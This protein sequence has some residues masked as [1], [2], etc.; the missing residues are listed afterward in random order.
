MS[1]EAIIEKALSMD[2]VLFLKDGGLSYRAPAGSGVPQALREEIVANKT[3]IVDYLRYLEI[4]AG[5]TPKLPPILRREAGREA[6][7]SYGQQQLMLVDR[8]GGGSRQFNIQGVFRADGALDIGALQAAIRRIVERH[9]VLRTHLIERDGDFV[10]VVADACEVPF[11]VVDISGQPAGER[12]RRLAELIRTDAEA[13]FDLERGPMLRMQVVRLSGR[14]HAILLCMHHVASDGWSLGVFVKELKR[15]Y[16]QALTGEIAAAPALT[17]QYADYA[18][19]QR[20]LLEGPFR[21]EAV[22]FWKDYLEGIPDCHVLPLDHARPAEPDVAAIRIDRRLDRAQ[23]ARLKSVCSARGATLFMLLQTAFSLLLHRF[24][25]A[26]DIVVGTPMSGRIDAALEPLVGLFINT[27][28]LRNRF[29]PEKT[30]SQHL[31]TNKERN[32]SAHEYQYLPFELLVEALNPPRSGAYNPIFQIWFVLQNNER[33][34]VELPGCV[35]R[36]D[37]SVQVDSAKYELNLYASEDDDGLA[38]DWVARKALFKPQTLD[39]LARQFERLL[40]AIASDPDRRIGEYPLFGSAEA[41][42]VLDRAGAVVDT[43]PVLD[44]F[45]RQVAA[46]PDAVAIRSENRDVSYR[47]LDALSD[48]FAAV[49][50]ASEQSRIGLCLNHG[51]DM[52]LAIWACIKAGK[53]Y[54]P[55]NPEYPLERLRYIVEDAGIGWVVKNARTDAVVAELDAVRRIDV[56]NGHGEDGNE[57]PGPVGVAPPELA[58]VLYTSGSTGR[59]KGVLQRHPHVAYYVDCYVSLL[60]IGPDDRL[61][62]IASFSHDAAVLDMFAAL[63]SGACL[64]LMDIKKSAPADVLDA[65]DGGVTIYHSS[66]S[67]FKFL[68]AHAEGR[69]FPALRAAVF[70]GEA[71]DAAT[72]R[73]AGECLPADCEV[74]NLYGSSEAT[75]VSLHARRVREGLAACRYLAEVMPGTRLRIVGSDGADADVYEPG[76]LV[77]ESAALAEGYLNLP[78]LTAARFAASGNGL[79]AYRTGDLGCLLPDGTIRFLGRR[80]N[81]F[82]L[83]GQRIEPEEIEA[84]LLGCPGV[85]SCLVAPQ[86]DAASGDTFIAAFV[87]TDLDEA[88]WP[89]LERAIR[90]RLS[91]SLPLYMVPAVISPVQ[92]L[93]YTASGK[94]DR[95]TLPVPLVRRDEA[96]LA[97]RTPTEQRLLSLWQ[98]VLQRADLGM[99]QNFFAVGGHSLLATRL[100]L[101]INQTFGSQLRLADVFLHQTIVE[102]ARLIDD[103][104]DP[105]M[106]GRN[107][108]V[109]LGRERYPLSHTQRRLHFLTQLED[110]SAH[111][112]LCAGLRLS[113]ELD[114]DALQM[115]LSALVERHAILR[116]TYVA[117][118]EGIEQKVNPP[119]PLMLE[120]TDLAGLATDAQ[121]EALQ[122]LLA[123]ETLRRFDLASEGVMAV[124]LVALGPAH[125]AAL[126]TIHHLAADGASMAILTREFMALYDG[127]RRGRPDP[128]PPLPFQ[129][130]DFA[131]WQQDALG[132]TALS[133]QLG[134]WRETLAGVPTVHRLPLDKPRPPQPDHV[135][136]VYRQVLDGELLADLTAL[137]QRHGCTMFLVVKALFSVLLAK[138]GGSRDVVIGVPAEGRNQ[139]GT[140]ALIGFFANTLVFRRELDLAADFASL[141]EADKIQA[142]A[143]FRHQDV[144][145]ELLVE[146]LQVERNLSHHPL[147][148]VFLAFQNYEREDLALEGLRVESLPMRTHSIRFDLE[149]AVRALDDALEL[150]WNYA[151]ALFERATVM[152]LAD[153]F[154]ALAQAVA[155]D[156]RRPLSALSLLTED[157]RRRIE[158][159]NAT[160]RDYD[161]TP[162]PALIAAQASRTPDA[163]AVTDGERRLDYRTLLARA[164][165]LARTLRAKGVGAGSLVGAYLPRSV[166]M[167]VGLLGIQRAGAAYVPLDPSYPPARLAYMAEDSRLRWVVT[168]DRLRAEAAALSEA[169]EPI[170]LDEVAASDGP[171][172]DIAATDDDLAYVIYTSGSTGRPKGVMIEHRQLSN[173]RAAMQECLGLDG[174]VWLAVTAYSFDISILELLCPLAQ[175]F[176]VVVGDHQRQAEPGGSFAELMA[177]H[178]VTHLQCTPSLLRLYMDLPEFCDALAALEV[179]MVGGEACPAPLVERLERHT[180]A[181]LMN[182]YGPTETTIWSS[183]ARL[184]GD[185]AVSI[186]RP[187]GNT[188]FHVVDEAL[189]EVPVGVRGELLIGG[190]GVARG[191]LG[192]DELTAERF[193]RLTNGDRVYRTGD[194]VRWLDHGELLY[195]GRGDT[196]VKFRGHRVELGEIEARLRAL[197]GV[198]EAAVTLH[199][200]AA[201]EAVLAAYLVAE[202]EIG[203][204]AA[205]VLERKRE[206]ARE[207]TGYMMPSAFV[208]L[209]RLP[210][211][212]NGKVDRASLP[213]PNA[214]ADAGFREPETEVER[215][216]AV[217]WQ[218]LLERDEPVGAQDNFFRLGGHSLLAT[219]MILAIDRRWPG[220]VR[221]KDIFERQSLAELAS[222]IEAGRVSKSPTETDVAK[223]SA[224]YEEMEW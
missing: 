90:G 33:I 212:P 81:Q 107:G 217:I 117:N 150:Q 153:G 128:L 43:T 200:P 209:D 219:R 59:P 186:G 15:F 97:P 6:P 75:L 66:A 19:W 179:L 114:Q 151:T 7:L 110:G 78:E 149:L 129:Y 2:V 17:V 24:S 126:L 69:A 175:G 113:G 57:V 64:Q 35:I 102:Q 72:L 170:S 109:P 162:L 77:V 155:T 22:E 44:R 216:L 83:N 220:V 121:E 52:V 145:F 148:Q 164:D 198:R 138:Y 42:A 201:G 91:S 204:E 158:G 115:A 61:L 185:R 92:S 180:K 23:L 16:E 134:Y 67:V 30:F 73:L 224:V 199:A 211:T 37:E 167:V 187:I 169:I 65:I 195:I 34:A 205:W 183:C 94:L 25:Q 202:A 203:D 207:L 18:G 137:A 85:R 133:E 196:Q 1:P 140:A 197:N 132:Q 190:D 168:D 86:S 101:E 125:H 214:V 221:L 215:F 105:A 40:D 159:W 139:P 71:P 135:G 5:T 98:R 144:P 54:V 154:R 119:A 222:H 208:V 62:Q 104:S 181:R 26:H 46:R 124:R 31:Q 70:G 189:Q 88:A 20:E 223:G 141:L 96:V 206:L 165:G 99:R 176:T 127:F 58:Y 218:E 192:R 103:A 166:D 156:C 111:Y 182:L 160:R 163:I 95:K 147:I 173:F 174:G 157:D 28:V 106:T 29:D 89:E 177:L 120:R 171:E 82:K 161:R 3:A 63:T 146:T 80:D 32:L 51:L 53:T 56:G 74:A 48:R 50:A 108:I 87:T 122:S 143:V 84:M 118:G 55:L 194:L 13:P 79:R 184:S 123:Q 210:M 116:T 47:E 68:F 172:T 12:E 213:P 14:E 36:P 4:Q 93:H 11:V 112:N 152:R 38:L 49:L 178:R 131:A 9:E 100:V 21:A 39:Y 60:A 41:S 191:Y 45:R 8:L 193:V 188:R 142:A 76:E 136:E 27:V 130:G 10:Q